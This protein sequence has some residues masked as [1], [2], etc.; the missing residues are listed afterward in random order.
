MAARG[1]RGIP[2]AAARAALRR[3]DAAFVAA[4]AGAPLLLR[5]ATEVP[6]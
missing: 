4:V 6:A 1:W 3:A 2:P 5:V